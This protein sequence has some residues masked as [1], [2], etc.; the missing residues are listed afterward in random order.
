MLEQVLDLY[1]LCIGVFLFFTE[2][3]CRALRLNCWF[4]QE[5][6]NAASLFRITMCRHTLP[7][8]KSLL[9]EGVF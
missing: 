8:L 5:Q 3:G 2:A 4:M 9:G 1:L 7:W 6:Q